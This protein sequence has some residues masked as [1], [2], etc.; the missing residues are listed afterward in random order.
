MI[1]T[2]NVRRWIGQGGPNHQ[3]PR[4]DR[5]RNEELVFS[6]RGGSFRPAAKRGPVQTEGRSNGAPLMRANDHP[7]GRRLN[8]QRIARGGDDRTDRGVW[9][10]PKSWFRE[11]MAAD[12]PDE[13]DPEPKDHPE[14]HQQEN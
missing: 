8:T 5:A 10:R 12:Q 11:M 13:R 4:T 9:R 2:I 1:A 3:G 7:G 14:H 6:E